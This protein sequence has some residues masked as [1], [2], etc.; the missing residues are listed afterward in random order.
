[1]PLTNRSAQ[2]VDQLLT[3]L[4][5]KYTPAGFI[6][7]RVCP[8]V[9][10]VKEQGKYPVWTRADFHRTDVDP[11]VPDRAKTKRID[12]TAS[13]E[14]Y[15]CEEYALATDVSKRERDNSTD[16]LG[17]RN[18]KSNGVRDIIALSREKRVKAL[19]DTVSNSSTPAN[20]WNVDLATIEAD[21]VTAKE[22]VYD[23]IGRPPNSIIIPWKVANAIAV[24]QDIREVL[25]YTVNGKEL[26]S[27]GENALPA[28]LW[29]LEV[30]VPMGPQSTESAEDA[31]TQTFAEVWGDDALVLYL[32][33][34]PDINNPSVAY[35]LQTAGFEVRSWFEDDPPDLE[36]IRV[37]DGILD[38]KLTAPDAGHRLIDLLS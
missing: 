31:A 15:T 34:S 17:L 5:R 1:M 7:D 32:Q 21:I 35:T 37:R 24:Q 6:A 8:R 23:D 33:P 3:N 20:N 9:S 14:D 4:G 29:G 18:T 2:L 16:V 22:A 10:V 13:T 19:L 28:R 12:F 11:L 30:I 36:V 26:L 25:K 27:L 38:E